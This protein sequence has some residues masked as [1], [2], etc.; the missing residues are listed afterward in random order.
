M[1]RAMANERLQKFVL[2]QGGGDGFFLMGPKYTQHITARLEFGEYIYE[3]SLAPT[4]TPELMIE[5]HIHQYG[6]STAGGKTYSSAKGASESVLKESHDARTTKGRWFHALGVSIHP[7]R[8][9]ARV[10][11]PFVQRSEVAGGWPGSGERLRDAADQRSVPVTGGDQRQR[12]D[13]V[14]RRL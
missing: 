7:V 11:G 2:E 8:A 3:F 13:C 1:L 5:E 4:N 14:S 9:D 10:R 12:T 6:G